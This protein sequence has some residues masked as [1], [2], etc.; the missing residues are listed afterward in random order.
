MR[1]PLGLACAQAVHKPLPCVMMMM[2]SGRRPTALIHPALGHARGAPVLSC[3]YKKNMNG[4]V[5]LHIP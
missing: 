2:H 4:I 1:A 3:L 5:P